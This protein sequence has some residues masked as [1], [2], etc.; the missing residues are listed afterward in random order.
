MHAHV[1]VHKQG[2]K[3]A[4]AHVNA[5]RPGRTTLRIASHVSTPLQRLGQL[6]PPQNSVEVTMRSDAADAAARRAA[7]SCAGTSQSCA[8]P[9][10]SIDGLSVAACA[11]LPALP[12]PMWTRGTLSQPRA[13]VR[14]ELM[15]GA[16]RGEAD[17]ASSANARRGVCCEF[18]RG[19][20]A[21]GSQCPE[22]H[23]DMRLSE[24]SRFG[25]SR[26]GACVFHGRTAF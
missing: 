15:R 22:G 14:C 10:P 9:V 12:A 18:A 24:L 20:C 17:G 7:H 21:R 6:L 1:H 2:D 8:G 13:P 11:S 19:V 25:C 4:C 26:G 23:V 3:R 5:P 16:R